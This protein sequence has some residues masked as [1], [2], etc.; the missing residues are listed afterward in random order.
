[1]LKFMHA[2]F[3]NDFTS[4]IKKSIVEAI[5]CNE[6]VSCPSFADDVTLVTLSKE[7]LQVLIDKPFEYSSKWHFEF[8]PTKYK[9]VIFGKDTNPK[10]KVML[11]ENVIQ[12]SNFENH[13][14]ILLAN[15]DKAQEEF[16]MLE[17]INVKM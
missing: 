16:F 10:L 15:C 8:S 2:L 12:A 4:D 14:G 11:G 7:G 3:N 1:M 5:I 6:V 13:L 9:L 17:F